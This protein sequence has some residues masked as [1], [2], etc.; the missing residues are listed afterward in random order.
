MD[1]LEIQD[2]GD[3][4]KVTFTNDELRVDGNLV[5]VI[6]GDFDLSQIV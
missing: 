5:A 2:L 6:N 1:S 3:G 4:S